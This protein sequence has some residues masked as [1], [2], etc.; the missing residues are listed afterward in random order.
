MHVVKERNDV[1]TFQG[2]KNL[3]AT[4]RADGKVAIVAGTK[5]KVFAKTNSC[6]ETLATDYLTEL[7][8]DMYV[9]LADR[10]CGL[11]VRV[12]D[13]RSRGP[14]FDSRRCQIF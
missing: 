9:N 1:E 14:G 8:S 7:D 13:Y 6:R 10:P 3:R 11:V 2:M 5:R 12:P 4:E